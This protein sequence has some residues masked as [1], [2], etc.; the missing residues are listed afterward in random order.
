MGSS[1]TVETR[2]CR[3]RVP[4]TWKVAGRGA[5]YDDRPTVAPCSAVATECWVDPPAP[6]R[7]LAARQLGLA[8]QVLDGLAVVREEP[9]RASRFADAWIT[10]V[11]TRG[12]D[13]SA[14]LQHQLTVAS[15]PLGCCLTLS[16]V[17][18]DAGRW[19]SVFA[20]IAESFEVPAAEVMA[21]V[22]RKSLVQAPEVGHAPTAV[23]ADVHLVVPVPNG[24]S[25]DPARQSLRGPE[26]A[27]I[28]VRAVEPPGVG[29]DEAFADA[30]AHLAHSPAFQPQGWDCGELEGGRRWYAIEAHAAPARTWKASEQRVQRQVLID[31]EGVLE[32]CIVAGPS[33]ENVAP[34]LAA[35]VG[36]MRR[37]APADRRLRI[38]EPWVPMVLEGGWKQP[39]PGLFVHLEAPRQVVV[40]ARHGCPRG[41]RHLAGETANALAADPGIREVVRRE[42]TEGT[43]KGSNAVRC[44]L[45]VISTEGLPVAVR[46]VWLGA[47]VD[48][49]HLL[50]QGEDREVVDRLFVRLLEA[51]EPAQL[52]GGARR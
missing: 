3:F 49:A 21:R 6:A 32:I 7:E 16:G 15:G 37:Q 29:L 38:P 24:W 30:L 51:V 25:L 20:E 4:A 34:A 46:A 52:K 10:V 45:D 22:T 41:L 5:A 47:D 28:S 2:F 50:V 18:R 14:L 23:L 19:S 11:R 31:D 8:H 17:E 12:P 39:S 40:V 42:L 35:V 33:P 13:G 26:S 9:A 43:W 44:T 27:E 48:A 36:G 1:V